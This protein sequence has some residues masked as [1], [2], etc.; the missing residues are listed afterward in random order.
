LARP[1]KPVLVLTSDTSIGIGGGD[2]ETALRYRLPIVYLVCNQGSL[3]GGVDCFFQGQIQSWDYLPGL[4]YDRMY[5]V[6]GCHREYVDKAA[7]VGPALRRAFNSGRTAVVQVDVDSRVVQPWFE[8]LSFRLG[9]IA[10]Q[11]DVDRIPEP[12]RTYLLEGRTPEV[13]EALEACGVP[14]SKTKKR[15]MAYDRTTC[16]SWGGDD[17]ASEQTSTG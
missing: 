6:L 12:F 8:S 13:E 5:E 10:H 1:G 16:L 9:V 15:V 2:I 3:A 4:R 11:L 17:Q 7:D 14:R